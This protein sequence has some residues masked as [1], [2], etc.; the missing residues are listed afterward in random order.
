MTAPAL[1]TAP[2]QS[3]A[4][5][6]AKR[7]GRRGRRGTMAPAIIAALLGAALAAGVT[8][9]LVSSVSLHITPAAAGL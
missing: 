7:R 6:A 5:G 9:L 3:T 4:S 1:D 2:A 8:W